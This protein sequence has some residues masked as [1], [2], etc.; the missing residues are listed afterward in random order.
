MTLADLAPLARPALSDRVVYAYQRIDDVALLLEGPGPRTE[1]QKAIRNRILDKLASV[2]S[3]L[4]RL[5]L[6][7]RGGGS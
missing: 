1:G 7:T 4:D 3:D 6:L 2:Q 5:E